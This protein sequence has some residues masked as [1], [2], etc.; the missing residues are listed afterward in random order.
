MTTLQRLS[1]ASNKL[2]SL[3]KDVG[4]L[5][6]LRVLNAND[7][8]LTSVPGELQVVKLSSCQTVIGCTWDCGFLRCIVRAST[9]CSG[10]LRLLMWSA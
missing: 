4:S 5:T 8:Q 2:T 3:P 1:L 6:A 7:N 10:C 9:R